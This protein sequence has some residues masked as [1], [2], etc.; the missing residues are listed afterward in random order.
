M[1]KF[2]ETGRPIYLEGVNFS[3]DTR[4]VTAFAVERD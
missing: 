4:T 2:S 3:K 1:G